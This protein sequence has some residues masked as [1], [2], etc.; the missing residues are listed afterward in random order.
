M[1]FTVCIKVIFGEFEATE[2]PGLTSARPEPTKNLRTTSV[3]DNQVELCFMK[4]TFTLN[5]ASVYFYFNDALLV[6]CVL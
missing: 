5:L 6:Q 3:F 4:A 2:R 1:S